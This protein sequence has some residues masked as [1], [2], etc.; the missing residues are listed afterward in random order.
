VSALAI[1]SALRGQRRR[2]TVLLAV[3]VVAGAITAHHSGLLMDMHHGAGMSSVV[4][5][6]LGVFSAVGAALV[7]V[8]MGVLALGRW[9]PAGALWVPAMRRVAGAPT[10]R[11][12]HGPFVVCVLC[13]SRR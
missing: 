13:V 11:T 6:C 1:R 5:I 8:S 2:L 7:A 10:A 4:E 12:R 3:V 9:R